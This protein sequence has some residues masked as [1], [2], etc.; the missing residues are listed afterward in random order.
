[1]ADLL[2]NSIQAHSYN[3]VNY[4]LSTEKRP[5]ILTLSNSISA[6]TRFFEQI[7]FANWGITAHEWLHQSAC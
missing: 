4:L 6:A 1:M 2:E 7:T 5:Q 3:F